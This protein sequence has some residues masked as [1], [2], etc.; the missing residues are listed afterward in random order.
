MQQIHGEVNDSAQ[1]TRRLDLR[2]SR[3]H[4]S[5]LKAMNGKQWGSEYC[6]Q[7]MILSFPPT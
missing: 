2:I 1:Y 3:V 7:N 6:K 5:S 4:L